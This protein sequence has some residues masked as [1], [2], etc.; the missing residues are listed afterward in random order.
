MRLYAASYLLPV[1]GPPIAGGAIAVEEGEIIAVGTLD[2]LRRVCPGDVTEFPGCVIMPGLV[3]AHCHL[4]LTHFPAWRMRDGM[5]YAPRSFVDWLIQVVKI[6]RGVT[7]DD[8]RHSLREGIRISHESGSTAVGDILSQRD[9][10]PL[11]AASHLTGRLFFEAVG[12]DP[13]RCGTLLAELERALEQPLG[14][15]LPGVSPHT[16]YTISEEFGRV[17]GERAR[18]RGVPCA[19][20]CAESAAEGSFFFDTSGPLAEIF[21]PHVH[22]EQYLPSPRRT[23][24]VRYLDGLGLLTPGSTAVHCV[25]VTSADAEIL[26]KRNI[27]IVLCPR[28]NNQLNV[29]T[30]PAHLYKKLGIPLALGTD[31]L[32]SNDS[33][34]LFDEARFAAAL[35]PDVFPPEELLYMIT[36]GGARVLG[37]E[38]QT[39]S[40]VPGKRADFIVVEAT[41]TPERLPER[42]IHEGKLR[43]VFA[44]GNAL[45]D[46]APS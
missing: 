8:F 5:E 24:P 22:W 9:L 7:S 40:L 11:Y 2:P 25:H 34:S 42:I 6:K 3:N 29:G 39:G 10:L 12:Q 41:G 44:R 15:F 20:H 30:A 17:L 35:W 13:A 27:S 19:I 14:S 32:A 18:R 33:L 1:E 16:P 36:L 21:Y 43:E 26:K 38:E 46:P 45:T 4:E 23:T 31:S 28:S 37:L